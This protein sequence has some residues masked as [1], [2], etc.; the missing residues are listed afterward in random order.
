MPSETAR[1]SAS[2]PEPE[3]ALCGW[4][5]ADI[6]HAAGDWAPFDRA[7]A[8]IAAALS[9]LSAHPRF[10]SHENAAVCIALSDDTA[11]RRLNATFRGKDKPTN[12]LSFPAGDGAQEP[13]A[14]AI[15]LGD[16]F[17]ARETLEAEALE[18]AIPVLHHLQHLTVHG[19][20]H[21]LGYDHENDDDATAMEGLEIEIL[22]RLNIANP[23]AHGFVLDATAGA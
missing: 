3:P 12:V 11:V 14:G 23:Y 4:L 18:L 7:H 9:A 20:L 19:V 21:L 2:D 15:F 5:V 10:T 16:V 6:V 8:S 1:E 17:V 22:K 13:D